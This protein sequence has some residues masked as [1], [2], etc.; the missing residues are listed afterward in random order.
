MNHAYPII[1]F[2]TAFL[3]MAVRAEHYDVYILAGQSNAGGHGYVSREFAH[4]SPLGD[5]GLVELGKTA[6]QTP[7]A[8]SL[9]IHWRGGNPGAGRP[10]LWEARSDGWIPMKAGYS[11]F[12]YN[13]QSPADLGAETVNH[14]FGAEVTFV[15]RIRKARLGE[16]WP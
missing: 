8:D 1:L 16:R 3:Q 12:G 4:F 14:P 5:D 10:V 7:Q 9:F 13:S 15:E 6:Y 2:L 11:L